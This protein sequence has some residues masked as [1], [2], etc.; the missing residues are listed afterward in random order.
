VQILYNPNHPHAPNPKGGPRYTFRFTDAAP[1]VLF[2][3]K[4]DKGPFKVRH[5]P[6][7]CRGLE[8]GRHHFAVKSVNA[9]GIAS[10][11]EK[12]AFYAGRRRKS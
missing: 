12:V 7:A 3:C 10:A 11:V 6:K 9:A 8:R 4:L 2:S 1:G 5:S